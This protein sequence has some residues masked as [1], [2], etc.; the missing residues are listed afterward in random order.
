MRL[1]DERA[2]TDKTIEVKP[3]ARLRALAFV[4]DVAKVGFVVTPEVERQIEDFA[5]YVPRAMR[6][7]GRDVVLDPSAGGWKVVRRG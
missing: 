2:L 6:E 3:N 5:I 4:R 1:S 7:Y